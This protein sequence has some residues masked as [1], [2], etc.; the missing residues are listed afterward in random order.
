MRIIPIQNIYT[1]SQ[2]CPQKKVNF[3][4]NSDKEICLLRDIFI[5]CKTKFNILCLYVFFKI[6]FISS[7][8]FFLILLT[9]SSLVP[10]MPLMHPKDI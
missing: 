6:H 4:G 9:S 3:K 7:N 10:D 1:K 2:N 8:A 5:V